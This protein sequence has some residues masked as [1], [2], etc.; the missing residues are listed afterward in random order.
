MFGNSSRWSRRS[1]IK[2]GGTAGLAAAAGMPLTATPQSKQPASS[3]ARTAIEQ[4]VES[5]P[6][7]DTHEHLTEEGRLDLESA[8][9]LADPIMRG[10]AR[11]L[12]NLDQKTKKLQA[13][14]WL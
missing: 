1:V 14:P 11:A 3:D 10:N 5:T 6:I 9:N 4:R 7:I 8:L 13:A 2:T 12:F